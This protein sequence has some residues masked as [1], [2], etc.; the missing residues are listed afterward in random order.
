LAFPWVK[1]L[2]DARFETHGNFPVLE[3]GHNEN[4]VKIN[5]A[6]ENDR[7]VILLYHLGTLTFSSF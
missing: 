2:R 4:A 1:V 7:K 5:L 6:I 3:D